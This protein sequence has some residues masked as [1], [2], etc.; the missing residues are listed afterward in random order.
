[1]LT[2]EEILEML[3][4]VQEGHGDWRATL[5]ELV[6]TF[7]KAV[8]DEETETPT[9]DEE[10]SPFEVIASFEIDT[11]GRRWESVPTDCAMRQRDGEGR[12]L[13]ATPSNYRDVL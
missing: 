13:S 11:E 2:N 12:W 6:D 1:M 8:A 10:P 4:D 9:S 5:D 3:I 7:E